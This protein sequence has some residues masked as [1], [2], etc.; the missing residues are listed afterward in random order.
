MVDGDA[1]AQGPVPS[2]AHRRK[3]ALLWAGLGALLLVSSGAGIVA[4]GGG[5]DNESKGAVAHKKVVA[6]STPTTKAAGTATTIPATTPAV[7]AASRGGA[8]A[9]TLRTTPPTSPPTTAPRPTTTTLKPMFATAVAAPGLVICPHRGD[10]KIVTISWETTN[11]TRVDLTY[12]SFTLGDNSPPNSR[13]GIGYQCGVGLTQVHLTAT[14]PGGQTGVD[15]SWNYT[16][17]DG[18]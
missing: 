18:S 1:G 12:P 2:D 15:V 10:V 6:T 13:I 4:C 5:D 17:V 11:A 7:T 14:G 3:R 8:T 16:I 9:T